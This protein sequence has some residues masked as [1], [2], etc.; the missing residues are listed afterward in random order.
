MC[1]WR[2][3]FPG[4]FSKKFEKSLRHFAELFLLLQSDGKSQGKK[5]DR[6]SPS[7]LTK[8]K[9]ETPYHAYFTENYSV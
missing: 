8:D 7:V 9:I 5:K 1:N 2:G 6:L 3:G 4:E